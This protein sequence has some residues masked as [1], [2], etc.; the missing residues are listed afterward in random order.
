MNLN[1][2]Y[3][4]VRGER[5]GPRPTR[6]R[7]WSSKQGGPD[8]PEAQEARRRVLVASMKRGRRGN[9]DK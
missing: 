3:H 8:T 7:A 6:V 9:N 4:A 1:E 5:L 2:A